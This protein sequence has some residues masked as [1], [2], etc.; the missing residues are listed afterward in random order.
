MIML[1]EFW[2]KEARGISPM[3]DSDPA[4]RLAGGMIVCLGNC[5]A[6]PPQCRLAFS[7][8]S[9]MAMAHYVHREQIGGV[10]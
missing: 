4:E 10:F 2:A 1:R 9:E 7:N 5:H 8:T 6:S 3:P